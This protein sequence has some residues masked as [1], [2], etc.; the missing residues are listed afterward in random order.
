[1][2]SLENSHP[3]WAA[4]QYLMA[5]RLIG[6][7]NQ[8]VVRPEGIGETWCCCFVKYVLAL[9]RPEATEDFGMEQLCVR[10]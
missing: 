1:M 5:G 2:E 7:Y 3:P 6:M 4:Y 9:A 10:L 8:P